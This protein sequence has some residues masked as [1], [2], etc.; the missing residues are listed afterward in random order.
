MTTAGRLSVVTVCKGR[1]HHL[2]QTLPT[3]IAQPGVEVVVVDYGCP[4]GTGDWVAAHYPEARLVRLSAADF[5]LSRGRNRGAAAARGNWLAFVDADVA[6]APGFAE[7]VGAAVGSDRF[8][9]AEPMQHDLMGT[10]VCPRAAFERT[11]GFDEAMRLWGGEDKDLYLRLHHLHGLIQGSFDAGLVSTIG[12]DNGQ[13]TR[14]SP[15]ADLDL[16]LQ[17]NQ[18]YRTIKLDL[19]RLGGGE[20]SA[21]MCETLFGQVRAGV[22][23]GD[24]QFRL[25]LPDSPGTRLAVARSLVYAI[26][27]G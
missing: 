22:E 24:R 5:C 19:I 11:G 15:V 10:V 21:E 25:S 1:L 3:Y 13:R 18:L 26:G 17:I 20:L 27:P 14:F 23:R 2:R 7:A 9:L 6:L 16:C 8:L 12:H 4:D